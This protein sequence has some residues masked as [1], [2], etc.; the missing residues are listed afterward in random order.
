MS[1]FDIGCRQN[2]DGGGSDR[3][4]LSDMVL[5]QL[6]LDVMKRSILSSVSWPSGVKEYH[7]V[8]LAG[9]NDLHGLRGFWNKLLLSGFR[10]ERYFSISFTGQ[11]FEPGLSNILPFD[12]SSL[13]SRPPW[14]FLVANTAPARSLLIS[15]YFSPVGVCL[16]TSMYFLRAI[17]PKFRLE[18]CKMKKSKI[19]KLFQDIGLDELFLEKIL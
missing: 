8:S 11:R 3:V 13:S 2:C 15:R 6:A 17:V 9:L 16:E 1:T 10:W 5:S 7:T 19:P 18:V 4:G 12:S 14:W